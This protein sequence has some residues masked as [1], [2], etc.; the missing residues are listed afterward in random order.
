MN[1]SIALCLV[2]LIAGAAGG[3]WYANRPTAGPADQPMPA[4]SPQ[5]GPTPGPNTPSPSKPEVTKVLRV[6]IL[7]Q[8]GQVALV[9][10]T[11]GGVPVAII[12]DRG[13]ARVIDLAWLA[14][15]VD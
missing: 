3:W 1:R 11:Q 12:S 5:P 8:N 6:E 14:R 13:K 7:D 2:S 15:K 9:L 4:P 10:T